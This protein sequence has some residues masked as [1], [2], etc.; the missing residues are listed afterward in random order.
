MFC[1]YMKIHLHIHPKPSSAIMKRI[2]LLSLVAILGITTLQAAP[3]K[4]RLTSP[5]KTIT[6]EASVSTS[7]TP[8]YRVW[9]GK[10]VVIESSKLGL[11]SDLGDFSTDITMTSLTPV[12]IEKETYTT[13]SEKR[14]HRTYQ[15][16]CAAFTLL[17]KNGNRL[18]VE[19]KATNEGVAFRYVVDGKSQVPVA[20]TAE[21]TTFRFPLLAKA[22]MHP[23]ADAKTG[24]AE[25]QPSYEEYYKMDIPVGTEAPLKAGWSFPAL[26]HTN[27]VWALIT[28]AG[29]T[30]EYVG[31]RLAAKSPN[32]EYA[33]A[34]P[35]MGETLTA[36]EPN[37]P[38]TKLPFASPWRAII[39]GSLAKVVESQMVTDL[40]APVAPKADF[41]WVKPGISSWSWGVLHDE[42]MTYDIQKQFVDYAAQMKWGYCLFDA[43]WDR[44]LGYEKVQELIDYAKSKNVSILLWYNSSGEW[45]S[46]KYSPKGALLEAEARRAE[47]ARIRKMGVAGIKVDFWPGDGQSAI[48]YYYD[49][50]KDAADNQLMVNFHGTTV[51]RG[52]SRTFPN[53]VSMEA[54]RGFEFTTFEQANTDQAPSHCTMLPFAR[55]IVGPMDF[56]P[57]CFGEII[58]KHR[59]TGN[60]MELALSVIFQSG[61]QHIVEIPQSMAKQPDYVIN[62]MKNIPTQ[63]EDIKLLDGYP[64]KYIVLARLSKG[65]WY[66]AGI[67]SQKETQTISVDIKKLKWASQSATII[68]DGDTNRLL[69]QQ[70]VSLTSGILTVKIV[71]NGGFVVVL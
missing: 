25:T 49:I 7:G 47:F 33:I 54:V 57:I 42:S 71:P 63:W 13:P 14:I 70:R 16:N 62:Y 48:Q 21:T 58:G 39:V 29:L 11:I 19:F 61:M 6:I 10:T 69:T 3:L 17:H 9:K 4:F 56:T 8:T 2:K 67:N 66:I 27:G 43:D 50:L 51:P 38:V 55:N 26:F 64:G 45:N 15:A 23:H 44:K 36:S 41:S 32:G 30:P 60:G 65:K 34:F 12:S 24:W 5:D 68:T 53:L 20:I 40:A 18:K 35:Q 52:W 28:E 46:T 31:T 37:H 59:R 1:F 22:W